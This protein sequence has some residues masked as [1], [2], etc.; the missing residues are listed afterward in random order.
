MWLRSTVTI[1]DLELRVLVAYRAADGVYGDVPP[2]MRSSTSC[3][4]SGYSSW[5]PP[6]ASMHDGVGQRLGVRECCRVRPPPRRP[7]YE[8]GL[9]R[10]GGGY[11]CAGVG[12]AVGLGVGFD[13][14]ARRSQPVH[15]GRAA[16]RGFW[17]AAGLM[18]MAHPEARVTGADPRRSSTPGRRPLRGVSPPSNTPVTNRR[19]RTPPVVARHSKPA[20]MH[21]KRRAV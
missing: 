4:I 2:P 12:Q 21:P 11:G 5:P 7:Y 9:S 16:H 18:Q 1:I 10:L 19:E 13:D 15:D 3:W 17:N 8:G 6:I 14:V 20:S